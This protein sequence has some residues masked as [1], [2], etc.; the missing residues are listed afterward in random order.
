MNID[1]NFC[2]ECGEQ[3]AEDEDGF[4]CEMCDGECSGA[5]GDPIHMHDKIGDW[6]RRHPELARFHAIRRESQDLTTD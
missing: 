2:P 6:S 3:L 4:W 1:I 5:C